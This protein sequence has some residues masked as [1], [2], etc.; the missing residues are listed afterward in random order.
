MATKKK[1]THKSKAQQEAIRAARKNLNAELSKMARIANNRLRNLE[2]AGFTTAS[3]AYRYI[4][5]KL[6]DKDAAITTDKSGRMKFNTNFRGLSYN[7]MIHEKSLLER[8]LYE[9]KTSTV[10]GVKEKFQRGYESFIQKHTP[11]GAKPLTFEEYA[12]LWQNTN[13]KHAAAQLGSSQVVKLIQEVKAEADEAYQEAINRAIND[14][15]A[16]VQEDT[17]IL[18]LRDN[19]IEKINNASI[20]GWFDT[21]PEDSPF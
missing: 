5:T 7:E 17:S 15:L 11:E 18:D 4:Y 6:Y 1:N 12:D 8:F 14:A 19:I 20:D 3:S 16:E 10:R 2:K 9:A 13:I 21:N